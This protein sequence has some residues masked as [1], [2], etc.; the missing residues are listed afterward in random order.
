VNRYDI[1]IYL[2]LVLGLQVFLPFFEA[3]LLKLNV[4]LIDALSRNLVGSVQELYPKKS[5]FMTSL[6]FQRCLVI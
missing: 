5:P 1:Q 6:V 2:L 3:G 4:I